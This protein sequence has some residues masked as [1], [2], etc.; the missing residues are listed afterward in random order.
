MRSLR[1]LRSDGGFGPDGSIRVR[2]PTSVLFLVP[3]L[4]E[5]SI[6]EESGRLLQAMSV[7]PQPVA[8][9]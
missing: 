1:P 9:L 2:R 3:M 5:Q 6:C 8:G 7:R 4:V